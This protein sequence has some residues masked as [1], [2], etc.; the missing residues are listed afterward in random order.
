[1]IKLTTFDIKLLE[2]DC[3]SLYSFPLSTPEVGHSKS[4][5]C[6][7]PTLPLISV[8]MH[9]RCTS[10]AMF[11][12]A[13]IYNTTD[14]KF[15]KHDSRVTILHS[16]PLL[17]KWCHH[18]CTIEKYASIF[19]RVELVILMTISC[20]ILRT[21]SHRP[22]QLTNER[23]GQ[24]YYDTRQI[25]LHSELLVATSSHDCILVVIMHLSMVCPTT[26]H[27]PR[28]HGIMWGDG[29]GFVQ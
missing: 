21:I 19:G 5:S 6:F 17:A 20:Q 4:I 11:V 8:C 24:Q 16:S 27:P 18:A 10:A 3:M 26:H 7:S 25:S 14:N 15:P 9:L 28:I 23:Y 29:K 12:T 22:P 1:M 2:C 13:I